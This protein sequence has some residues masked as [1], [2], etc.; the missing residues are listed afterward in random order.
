V[1]FGSVFADAA[2]RRKLLVGFA[3]AIL[4][5]VL[6]SVIGVIWEID[7]LTVFGVVLLAG[8]LGVIG[9]FVATMATHL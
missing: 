4:V 1:E 3:A 5:A 8:V 2:R 9:K 7:G 6:S